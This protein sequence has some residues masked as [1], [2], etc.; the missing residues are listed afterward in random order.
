MK[1]GLRVDVTTSRG[2]RLGVP[3]LMELF[4]RHD[5]GATFF[6]ALGPERLLRR[7]WLPGRELG[8]RRAA[9]LREVRDSGFEVGI[10]AF[11][12]VRWMDRSVEL[13]QAWTREQ[14][15][16]A[17]ASFMRVF[18]VPPQAHAA[19][20]WRMNRHAWRLTQRLGFRYSSDTRGSCPYIPVRNA[21]IVACPQ[22]PTTLPTF[23]ELIARDGIRP[24]EAVGA[25][26]RASAALPLTG[27]VF[28]MRAEWEGMRHAPLLDQ[29][30]AGWRAQGYAF[31]A[32]QDL[33]L[34][35]NLA[36]LPRHTVVEGMVPGRTQPV[37]LQGDEFLS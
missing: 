31:T 21:E 19:S 10:Q 20:G 4:S 6:F 1:L 13:G 9:L 33:L 22:L 17:C 23:A 25:M 30:L 11:D 12:P 15:E 24:E 32:V 26:L 2:V 27:H 18:G 36:R 7:S 28:S 34:D 14:M 37:A 8:P 3:R 35:V 29:L 16:H 5:A